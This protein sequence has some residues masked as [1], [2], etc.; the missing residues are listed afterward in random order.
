MTLWWM[1]AATNFLPYFCAP[2]SFPNAGRLEICS[3]HANPCVKVSPTERLLQVEEKKYK[4]TLDLL[5]L[6]SVLFLFIQEL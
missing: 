5:Y 3:T 2:S 4:Q 1:F 6:I